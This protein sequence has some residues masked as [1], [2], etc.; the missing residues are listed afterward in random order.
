MY[1]IGL[2]GGIATGKSLIS[3]NLIKK[4]YTLIDGDVIARQVVEPGQPAF[5][6]IE[7]TF[8]SSV[9]KDGQLDRAAMAEVIF[10]DPEKR[11]TLNRIIH[12][13]IYKVMRRKVLAALWRREKY[14]FLD[15]PLL[16]ESGAMVKYLSKVIVVT[17]PKEEQLKRLMERN[18]FSEE[19]AK[20]RVASQWPL[21][22]KCRRADFVIDNSGS[23]EDTLKQLDQVLLE[24]KDTTYPSLRYLMFDTLLLLVT[25]AATWSICSLLEYCFN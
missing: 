2:T 9:I 6:E 5:I 20:S 18:S 13:Q 14:V 1:L 7:K 15:L 17:C 12:P 10:N 4:G 21:E 16:Y 3:S 19:E 8:G 25:V 23:I 11:L 22:E 24:L